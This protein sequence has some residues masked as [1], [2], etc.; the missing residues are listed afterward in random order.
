MTI[1]LE[2]NEISKYK[3][4]VKTKNRKKM[5]KIKL[6]RNNLQKHKINLSI[7]EIT[8]YDFKASAMSSEEMNKADEIIFTDGFRVKKLKNR[9]ND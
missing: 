6:N 1:N 9:Y 2:Q 8:L 4:K 5:N 7:D 3:K